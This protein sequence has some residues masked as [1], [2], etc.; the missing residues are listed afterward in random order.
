MSAD[1]ISKFFGTATPITLEEAAD[2]VDQTTS[3]RADDHEAEQGPDRASSRAMSDWERPEF[4]TIWAEAGVFLCDGQDHYGCPRHPS[5]VSLWVDSNSG[6]FCCRIC[7][8]MGTG[9]KSLRPVADLL[10]VPLTQNEDYVLK[11]FGELGH[12]PRIKPLA[13][14]RGHELKL[15]LSMCNRGDCEFC[16]Y[17][18]FR[19]CYGHFARRLHGPTDDGQPL[20]W[21]EIAE[22]R[23]PTATKMIMRQKGNYLRV[24]MADQRAMVF[25]TTPFTSKQE[26]YNETRWGE[27]IWEI[28]AWHLRE[29]GK[30]PGKLSSSAPWSMER[31]KAAMAQFDPPAPASSDDGWEMATFSGTWTD[32]VRAAEEAG[33]ITFESASA[34]K[35]T[36][37]I[38]LP[39][40]PEE[41][42]FFK[43]AHHLHTW[44][45]IQ[46]AQVRHSWSGPK[47]AKH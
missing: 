14:M 11:S 19:R 43:A 15:H 30:V 16:G 18:W 40:D 6:A 10:V 33:Y 25:S 9:L 41:L 38:V 35:H 29:A 5:S 8:L 3:A 32:F 39:D 24:P 21:G 44:S 2:D 17:L 34:V 46:A 13:M 12:C 37:G 27:A 45:E 26:V 23:V 1:A 36:Y 20:F 31:S 42:L 4:N 28:L 22:A 47:R 7:L